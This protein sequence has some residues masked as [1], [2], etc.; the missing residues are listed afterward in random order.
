MRAPA[1]FG[2]QGLDWAGKLFTERENDGQF[3]AVKLSG[4]RAAKTHPGQ[5]SC[6]QQQ[7]E[8][9]GERVR[10]RERGTLNTFRKTHC[11]CRNCLI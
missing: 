2:W 8:Q 6:W 7:R 11:H 4:R 5:D 10:M 3:P 1:G 9:N